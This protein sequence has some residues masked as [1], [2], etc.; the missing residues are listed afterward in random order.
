MQIA[1]N[2]RQHPHASQKINQERQRR[3]VKKQGLVWSLLFHKDQSQP[4]TPGLFI[5]IVQILIENFSHSEHVDSILLEDS[6][7]SIVA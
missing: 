5:G 2:S 6:T 4:V 7:H 1:R 3:I